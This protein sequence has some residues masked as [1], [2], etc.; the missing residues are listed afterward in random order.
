MRHERTNLAPEQVAPQRTVAVFASSRYK[1]VAVRWNIVGAR[2]SLRCGDDKLT[3]VRHLIIASEFLA[4]AAAQR[5]HHQ[6]ERA[7]AAASTASP[8]FSK[9]PTR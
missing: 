1:Q 2:L 6:P 4:K 7:R 8:E 3:Q 9:T 5:L